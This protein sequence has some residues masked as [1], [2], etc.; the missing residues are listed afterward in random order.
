MVKYI[1][2]IEDRKEKIA[3][4]GLT[5]RFSSLTRF[6]LDILSAVFLKASGTCG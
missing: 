1:L 6:P 5:G 3:R 2:S 4:W